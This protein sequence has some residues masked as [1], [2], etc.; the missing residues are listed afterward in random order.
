MTDPRVERLNA[1]P[2]N[3]RFDI[4]AQLYER[5]HWTR[6][7][8]I[9]MSD[10]V[11]LSA[12]LVLPGDRA[13]PV[14]EPLPTVIN[15]TPYN[16]IFQRGS[17]G[18][19]VRAL[20]ERIGGSDRSHFTGRDLL[21][22]LA[23]GAPAALSV[24]PTLV[25]RGYAY[26]MVDV[27]GTGTSTGTWDFF[28]PT[29]QR[30]YAEVLQW[31]RQ[32]PWCNG[33]LAL[34][35]ISYGALASLLTAG[36]QPDGLAAVFAIE[37]GEDAVRELGLPG[38][39]P[40]PLVAVWLGAVNL[41][42]WFPS[43]SGLRRTGAWREYLR[44]RISSPASWMRHAAQ[45]ALMAD[46]P[47]I[48]LNAMWASRV[49]RLDKITI[50]T[51]IHGGWH[52]VYSRSN[53][54]IYQR[55]ATPPGAKQVVVDDCYHL[56]PGSG[57]GAPDA[58]QYLDELQCAWFDRW[59]KGIR[60]NIEYY[61]PITVRRLGGGWLSCDQYPDPAARVRRLYLSADASGSA[62]H[63]HVDGALSFDPPD[64]V[65]RLP[66]PTRRPSIR[67]NNTAVSA[68]GLATLLG[69]TFGSDDRH[70][71]ASAVTFTTE[72]FDADVVVSG[73]LNLHLWVKAEGE[74]AFW[75]VTVT[76][77]E[78]D[79]AS[80]P[81]SRGALL[82]SLRAVDETASTYVDGEL[83]AAEHPMT[84]ESVLPVVPGRPFDIDID[85]NATDAVIR[86]GHRLR[87]AV[88]R[89]GFPRYSLSRSQ[90][91]KSRGQAIIID[92]AH[93]SYLS[94]L[95]VGEALP[96]RFTGADTMTGVGDETDRSDEEKRRP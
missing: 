82:S 33:K 10:G 66:V 17:G 85:I 93:P 62:P 24:S 46:H 79:G 20:G 76:D 28:S 13:K 38:G 30:D 53:F 71:E 87:V 72:P 39:V 95:A 91:R 23:G 78:P 31:A 75:S 41:L 74:E 42:K 55:I 47:D 35:G 50:P 29:E 52:D 92:P 22:A 21:H 25:R 94:F 77:V 57:F 61:G 11:V 7:V 80:A 65:A 63:A 18:A 2:P 12:D 73:P 36:L 84:A 70:A 43:L 83:L 45:I 37:G 5:M 3:A 16:K 86:A 15:F 59:L 26:L 56:A 51:W 9:R 40:S 6:N 4:G 60:N 1:L 32:Q 27:R 34:T 68:I 88:G 44:D 81:V 67:S 49:A 8:G 96:R 64:R 19:W 89:G 14:T 90:R 69:R 58:P 54:R 48:L